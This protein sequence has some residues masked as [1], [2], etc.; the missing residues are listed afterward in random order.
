V[1]MDDRDHNR[2]VLIEDIPADLDEEDLELY[3]SNQRMGGG[4]ISA[5]LLDESS[6]TALVTFAS[7]EG[8]NCYELLELFNSFS[9]DS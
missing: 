5:N 4:E 7:S 1:T 6:R 8:V 9:L 3:L 2:T